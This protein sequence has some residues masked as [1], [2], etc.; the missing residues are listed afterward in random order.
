[1]THAENMSVIQKSDFYY[2]SRDN[3]SRWRSKP[4]ASEREKVKNTQRIL[5]T[6][7]KENNH[8]KLYRKHIKE[9][10]IIISQDGALLIYYPIISMMLTHCH[11]IVFLNPSLYL[12]NW[13]EWVSYLVGEW[14]RK[15]VSKWE[16]W[17][18]VSKWES[19][20]ASEWCE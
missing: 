12:S 13:R 16:K 5:K 6:E 10:I 20:R 9:I 1:M 14:E 2:D 8:N 19:K 3:K 11:V 4:R 15:P 17:E 7:N 18:R